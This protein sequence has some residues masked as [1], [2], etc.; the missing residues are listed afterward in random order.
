MAKL[1]LKSCI[2]YRISGHPATLIFDETGQ[3]AQGL[4]G[5][6]YFNR[7]GLV[8]ADLLEE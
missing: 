7:F 3:E 1:V 8:G 5:P 2:L 6:Q 4:I